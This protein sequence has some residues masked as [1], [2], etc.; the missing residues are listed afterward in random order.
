MSWL[1]NILSKVIRWWNEGDGFGEDGFP[2]FINTARF[3]HG[4][5]G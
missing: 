5:R 3:L 4:G 2:S 1:N